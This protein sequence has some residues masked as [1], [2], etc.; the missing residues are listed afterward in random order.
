MTEP[1]D[2]EEFTETDTDRQADRKKNRRTF[3]C[4][5]SG[6]LVP[7]LVFAVAVGGYLMSLRNAYEKDVNY[8][9][10]T[11]T[12]GGASDGTKALQG[13]G[14]NILLLGSD[15][16]DP[17]SAEGKIV[18][19]QRSDVIMW[20][21][22]NADNSMA[23]V[24][25]FPRDLYVDIPGHGKDKV[26]AALA[27]GGV[28]LATQTLQN[29]V[30]TKVD[31]VALVDFDGITGI[32]D[33]LGGVDVQVP[34]TFKAGDLQFTKGVQHMNGTEALIFVRQRYQ[35][36]GGDFDRNTN[37]RAVLKA[38][39]EKIVS[40]GTLTDPGKVLKVTEQISPFLT[41]DSKLTSERVAQLGLD[42]RNLRSGNIRYFSAPHGQPY[43]TKGG[44]SVV[45]TD[46]A[47][48]GEFRTAIQKDDMETYIRNNG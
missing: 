38:L 28:P 25:S 5:L 14:T 23:Y 36:P 31:H 39:I 34:Q 11:S 35:L 19:G 13:E 15:K 22:I 10:I 40:R 27:Y 24:A 12:D 48:M 47:T 6:F 30:G 29:Y 2:S 9:D 7:V 18:T 17:N 32:V 3:W 45:A 43:M 44:A 16:R 8:V 33:T 41:V 21:H 26:N 20:V 1:F 46:E 4:C 37:Q 42:N